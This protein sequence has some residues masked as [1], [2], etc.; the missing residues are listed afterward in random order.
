MKVSIGQ[1]YVEAGVSFP[2]SHH[3]QR[4]LSDRLSELATPG[5]EFLQYSRYGAAFDLADGAVARRYAQWT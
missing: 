4:W 3:M 5:A 1:I 2:F